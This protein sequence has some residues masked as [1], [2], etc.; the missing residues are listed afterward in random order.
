M[1]QLLWHMRRALL[2]TWYPCKHGALWRM[3]SHAAMKQ[4]NIYAC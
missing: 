1:N 3:S 4:V 2:D